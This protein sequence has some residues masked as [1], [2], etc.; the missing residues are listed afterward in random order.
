MTYTGDRA[1]NFTVIYNIDF[2]F[3][4][5]FLF[6]FILIFIF[7][8]VCFYSFFVGLDEFIDPSQ[9][10]LEYGGTDV[11]LGEAPQHLAFLRLSRD[12]EDEK[13]NRNR[14]RSRS[15][16]GKEKREKGNKNNE[17]GSEK[18]SESGSQSGSINYYNQSLSSSCS[19]VQDPSSNRSNHTKQRKS[20]KRKKSSSS[21]SSTPV[22][23]FI[24]FC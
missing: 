13:G 8:L 15:F 20:S 21:S 6:I 14:S 12:W 7:N 18:G 5:S 19:S 3:F 4:F 23:H 2:H 10:P 24:K 22:K 17:G 9:R 1:F 11:P 16:G